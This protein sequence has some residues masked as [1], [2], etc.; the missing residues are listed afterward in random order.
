VEEPPVVVT[1]DGTG[2]GT[3]ETIED[4]LAVRSLIRE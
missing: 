1:G 2:L 4:Q 3:W